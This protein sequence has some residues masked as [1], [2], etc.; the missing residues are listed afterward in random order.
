M[1]IPLADQGLPIVVA[2]EA[3]RGRFDQ[4][5]KAEAGQ[6]KLTLVEVYRRLGDTLTAIRAS[7]ALPYTD[8]AHALVFAWKA[9]KLR[10][11]THDPRIAAIALAN[12]ATLV[13]RNARDFKLIPGLTLDVWP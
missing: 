2:E 5:R 11:G 9:L 6:G 8:A 12:N 7:Q 3:I 13:T 1:A 4:V 10:I